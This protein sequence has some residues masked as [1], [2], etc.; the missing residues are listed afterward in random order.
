MAN[1]KAKTTI[2]PADEAVADLVRGLAQIDR[3]R[4]E[5]G[6][7]LRER[8]DL[9]LALI[10]AHPAAGAISCKITDREGFDHLRVINRADFAAEFSGLRSRIRKSVAALAQAASELPELIGDLP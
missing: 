7:L 2:R 1:A 8:D 3:S 9:A 6:F 10:R 4:A 5:I